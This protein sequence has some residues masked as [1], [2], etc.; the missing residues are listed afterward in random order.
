MKKLTALAGAIVTSVCVHA[1]SPSLEWAKSMGGGSG[2]YGN[3]IAVSKSG[4]IYC[5][6]SFQG[7]VDFDPS[8]TK[9][10]NLTSAGTNNVFITKL[11]AAGNLA[12]AK[13]LTGTSS[14]YA[15]AIAVDK[16]GNVYT[17]GTFFGT[18]DF[19]PGTGTSYASSMGGEDIFI[20]K[21]DSSGNFLW[22]KNMGGS[23]DDKALSIAIDKSGNVYTTGSFNGSVNFDPSSGSGYLSASGGADVF[24]LKLDPSGNFVWANKMG[25]GS[26][27]Y[28][29][30]VAVDTFNNVYTSGYFWGTANFDPSF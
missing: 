22:V 15:Y 8:P 16:Q 17:A 14:D 19:D 7:T 4:S 3:S 21:L 30:A 23:S 9:T 1:Q 5:A 18:V 12:W 11:D 28:G 6:G 29:V 26:D 27:D 2:D 20:S 10:F 25:G 24:V 13:A